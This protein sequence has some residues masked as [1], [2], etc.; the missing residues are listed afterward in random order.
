M[1]EEV[2]STR[3]L[4]ISYG[5][6]KA[7]REVSFS[8]KRGEIAA[9]IGANGAGKTSVLRALSGM[10]PFNGEILLQG[11]SI[12]GLSPDKLLRRGLAHVPEGRGIF[13]NLTVLENLTLASWIRKKNEVSSAFEEVFFLFPRLKERSAQKAGTLS[14][15]E[16][17]M[18][19]LARALVA[20]P[21]VLLLDEP[22]M[23]LAPLVL[24]DI[25]QKIAEI[26]KK[27]TTLLLVEQNA[28]LAL[29]YASAAYV[30]ETGSIVRRGAAKEMLQDPA[31]K[32]AYLGK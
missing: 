11:R 2:L 28:N 24:K 6:I 9:L 18:L 22:S 17:Q 21:T 25:F 1:S 32:A 30:M 10:L 15:G 12:R 7:V 27:G 8:L 16:Q 13:S 29:R 19:A 14:G 23:G 26:N 3:N 31:I 4:S 5:L 20:R